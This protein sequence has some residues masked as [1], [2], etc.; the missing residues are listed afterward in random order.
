MK[1]RY[2]ARKRLLHYKFKEMYFLVC[3][4]FD[5]SL[6]GYDIPC[7]GSCLFFAPQSLI[8]GGRIVLI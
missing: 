5:A 8:G 1:R 4:K 3:T 2:W 7:L 6:E